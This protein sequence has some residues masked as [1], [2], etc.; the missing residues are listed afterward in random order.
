MG[1]RILI[2]I[3][4]WLLSVILVGGIYWMLENKM[5]KDLEEA[6]I[7]MKQKNVEEL[8][9]NLGKLELLHYKFKDV[10]FYESLKPYLK[11]EYNIADDEP[12]VVVQGVAFAGIDFSTITENDFQ[13]D[14]DSSMMIVV[15]YPSQ[16]SYTLSDEIKMIGQSKI[17]EAS[18]L[19]ALRE[20]VK[21]HDAEAI[22]PLELEIQEDHILMILDP[23]LENIT[24]EDVSI[25]F[26][27]KN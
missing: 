11:K 27:R 24:N 14:N 23:L 18:I 4:P 7:S 20:M 16:F 8:I 10:L 5:E 15:P 26:L 3:F 25:K 21:S 6:K 12:I 22:Q 17:D 2:R 9:M 19:E 1:S 13:F